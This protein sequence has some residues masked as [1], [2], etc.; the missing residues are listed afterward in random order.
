MS[1][2]APSGAPRHRFLTWP[3]T[4]DGRRAGWLS[5]GAV[6]LI[7]LEGLLVLAGL[8]DWPQGVRFA[9]GLVMNVPVLLGAILAAVYT[10]LALRKGDRSI[11]LLW[12]LLLGAFAAMFVVAEFAIPH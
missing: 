4:R 6:G 11:V 9:V 8:Y 2:V 10:V 1:I 7:L 3:S 12:P 5:L